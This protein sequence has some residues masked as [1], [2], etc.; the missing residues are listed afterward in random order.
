MH[1]CRICGSRQE[2]PFQTLKERPKTGDLKISMIDPK[3]V[4]L[5]NTVLTPSDTARHSGM[6]NTCLQRSSAPVPF[7]HYRQGKTL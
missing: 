1:A 6:Q 7:V 2:P 3:E 5:P 4:P